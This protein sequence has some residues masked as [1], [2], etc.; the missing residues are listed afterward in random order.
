MSKIYLVCG[1]PGQ[2]KSS[3]I[4]DNLTP[5]DVYVSRDVVRYYLVNEDEP[6]F[7]KEK[8]VLHVFKYNVEEALKRGDNVWVDATFL[9]KKSRKWV[10]GLASQYRATI[11]VIAFERPLDLCLEWNSHR[12]GRE[13]VPDS[14]ISRMHEQF[15]EPTLEEGFDSIKIVK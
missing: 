13:R 11:Q 1:C 5:G 2:G 9:T 4:K 3:W 7:S 10:L 12:I 14:A 15:E 6:Y 8:E